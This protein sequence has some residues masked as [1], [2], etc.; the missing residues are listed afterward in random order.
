MNLNS[1]K[2]AGAPGSMD[3][4]KSPTCSNEDAFLREGI[5]LVLKTS[6][7]DRWCR[8]S[9]CVFA[10]LRAAVLEPG[11]LRR[12]SSRLVFGRRLNSLCSSQALEQPLRSPRTARRESRSRPFVR[13]LLPPSDTEGGNI[14]SE[15]NHV[16][17]SP[18]IVR[19]NTRDSIWF[20][21][22]K[23]RPCLMPLFNSS[24]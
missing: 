5:G 1:R 13:D 4:S 20:R 8:D 17:F 23:L 19:V 2:N 16:S 24:K 18:F 15:Q 10:T 6:P 7:C 22:I 11:C 14:W 9:S 3:T 21:K 12:L